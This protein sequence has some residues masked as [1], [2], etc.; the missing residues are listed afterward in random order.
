MRVWFYVGGGSWIDKVIQWWTADWKQ[1]WNGEW[2]N[3]PSHVELEVDGFLWSASTRYPYWYR[4]RKVQWNVKSW[5]IYQLDTSE[6]EER[7]VKEKAESMLGM[8]YDWLNIFGGD[9]L[10]LNVE[11]PKRITCDESVAILL[12]ETRYGAGL[13]DLAKMNPKRLEDYVRRL[14]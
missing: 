3:V 2:R 6:E 4:K 8:K 10:K 13:K 1:K 12:K 7:R 11:N 5:R 14:G 9:V